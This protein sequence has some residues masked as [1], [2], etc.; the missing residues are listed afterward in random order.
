MV[1]KRSLSLFTVDDLVVKVFCQYLSWIADRNIQ[2]N[3]ENVCSW[4]G[5]YNDPASM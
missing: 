2:D 3:K 1:H 5:E 4:L